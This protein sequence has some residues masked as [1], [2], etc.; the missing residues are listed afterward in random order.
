VVQEAV[1]DRIRCSHKAALLDLWM[2]YCDVLSF[3]EALDYL[4]ASQPI[5]S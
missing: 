5:P 2:K 4:N 3:S 1:F